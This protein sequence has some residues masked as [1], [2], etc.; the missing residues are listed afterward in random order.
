MESILSSPA[1]GT[2]TSSSNKACLGLQA[3]RCTS[4]FWKKIW[5]L[6]VPN[7]VKHLAWKACKDSL[8]T[9]TNMIRRRVIIEG[10]CDA[11]KLHQEDVFMPCSSAQPCNLFRDLGLNGITACFRRAFLSLIFLSLFLQV[12]R[13]LT[14]LLLCCGQYGIGGITCAW[15]SLHSHSARWLILLKIESWR[16]LLVAWFFNNPDRW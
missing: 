11:C 16:E 2:Y 8:P 12:T 3:I 9:K 4:L 10:Y 6:Q 5:G 1:T 15:A 14:F 13:S 7:K